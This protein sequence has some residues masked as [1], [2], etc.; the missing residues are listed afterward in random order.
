MEHDTPI[1]DDR[2]R[3]GRKR[4][5]WICEE[6]EDRVC[7]FTRADFLAHEEEYCYAS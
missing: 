6:N 7:Y 4:R 3:R 5:V 1:Y 2:P